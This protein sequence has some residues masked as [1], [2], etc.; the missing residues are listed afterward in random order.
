MPKLSIIT[1]NFNNVVG[2][3]KTIQSVISQTFNNYSFII[4]DGGSTDRSVEVIKQYASKLSYWVSE[5]DKG[6]YCAQNKGIAKATGEYCLFL[7][8]GDILIN[9]DILKDVFSSAP[10]VDIVSCDLSVSDGNS[11]V[12]EKMPES[13]D[14]DYFLLSSISHPSTLIRRLLF[15]KIGLFD[16][17]FKICG[18]Y[19]FFLRALLINKA[20][21][22]HIPVV[23]SQFDASGI[24]SNSSGKQLQKQERRKSFEKYYTIE[25]VNSLEENL[26]IKRSNKY[27]YKKLLKMI[28]KP[29]SR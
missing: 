22:K 28:F 1:I 13:I 3:E 6:I 17:S 16:E 19:D 9:N 7:N 4:I 15:N 24:S 23:L 5:A 18:D 29:F 10:D 25:V 11:N 12:I 20:T 14:T 8:S 21:Y 27:R 2:L 26:K